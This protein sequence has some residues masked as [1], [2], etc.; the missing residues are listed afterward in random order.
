[1]D[2][3]LKILDGT[4]TMTRRSVKGRHYKVDQDY[5]VQPHRNKPSMFRI[6]ITG[7]K[8]E[9]LGD[10]TPEDVKLEGYGSKEEFIEAWRSVNGGYNPQAE[11]I[12]YTFKLDP[13]YKAIGIG[14]MRKLKKIERVC[15]NKPV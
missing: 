3:I 14:E 9:R 13:V 1:M 5:A 10:I 15:G 4:K 6:A 8:L 7:K 2:H 12:A 11:V